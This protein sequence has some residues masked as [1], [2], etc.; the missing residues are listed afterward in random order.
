MWGFVFILASVTLCALCVIKVTI[1][2]VVLILATA[3]HT[4]VLTLGF[5]EVIIVAH[6]RNWIAPWILSI[7]RCLVWP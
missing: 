4:H 1:I 7:E 3:G 2:M 6:P 5:T